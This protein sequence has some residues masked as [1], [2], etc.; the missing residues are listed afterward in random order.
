MRKGELQQVAPPQTLY[1]RPVNLFVG[2]FIGSPAMNLAEAGIVRDDG[3]LFVQLGDHRLALGDELLAFR[4]KLRDYV[5]K[6]VVV[7]IR[8]ENLEDAALAPETPED[9]R[10]RGVVVLREPLGSEIVAHFTVNAPPALTED[11][12]ELA[13]DVG[14]E[15]AVKSA[16][17]ADTGE[18]ETVMVGRFGP[19][20]RIK[21]GDTVDVAVETGA[22]HFFDLDTGLGIYGETGNGRPAT[23][24]TEREGEDA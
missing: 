7:G 10:L 21:N 23:E 3:R 15:S 22:L 18:H 13:R 11:V 8:P 17:V 6:R 1:E 12:R 16:V 24:P 20:S 4:P 2:G 5:D 14:Q 9:Q 19:R